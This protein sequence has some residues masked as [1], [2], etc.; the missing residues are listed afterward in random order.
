MEA[1]IRCR[2]IVTELFSV[3]RPEEFAPASQTIALY[4]F[5]FRE[6]TEAQATRDAQRVR[7]AIAVLEEERETWR[8]LCEQ[9]PESPS[10]GRAFEPQEITPSSIPAIGAGPLARFDNLSQQTSFSLDG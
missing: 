10:V 8:L 2:G 7:D 3:V 9:L 1:I 5:L 6:L 4:V